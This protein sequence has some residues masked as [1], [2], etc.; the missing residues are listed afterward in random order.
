[1]LEFARQGLQA[2]VDMGLEKV[3]IM[4]FLDPLAEIVSTGNTRAEQVIQRWNSEFARSPVE[5]VE[6]YRVKDC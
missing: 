6:A 3:E 4:E 2:R 5:F 1:M